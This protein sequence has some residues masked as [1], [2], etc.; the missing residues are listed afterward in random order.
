[1]ANIEIDISNKKF[2][3]L[4]ALKRIGKTEK[5]LFKCDCGNIHKARKSSVMQGDTKSCG[6]SSYKPP[7]GAANKNYNGNLARVWGTIEFFKC[8]TWGN[9][10]RRCINIELILKKE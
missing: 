3:K 2:N 9:M 7:K 4:T 10:R 1:M 6:C 8:Q 5:W